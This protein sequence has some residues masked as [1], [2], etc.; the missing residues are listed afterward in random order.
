MIEAIQSGLSGV[1]RGID[2]FDAAAADAV[3]ATL[4]LADDARRPEH[5]LVGSLVEMMLSKREIQVSSRVIDS[6]NQVQQS[7]LDILA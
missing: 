5:D 1:R 2:R 4:P 7:L 6:A 3:R